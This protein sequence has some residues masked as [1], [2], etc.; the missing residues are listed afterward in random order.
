MPIRV[1][2]EIAAGFPLSVTFADVTVPSCPLVYVNPAFSKLT[3]YDQTEVLGRNCRF[4]QGENTSR[5]HIAM[6]SSAIKAALPIRIS[7]Q[8]YRKDG[9]EFTN[10]VALEPVVDGTGAPVLY[11]GL[12]RDAADGMSDEQYEALCDMLLETIERRKNEIFTARQFH[13]S[14]TQAVLQTIPSRILAVS[15]DG[16][17]GFANRAALILL[18][19]S[20]Y[21]V[22]GRPIT[23]V[24][25]RSEIG[26]WLDPE[27]PPGE[28]RFELT[29]MAPSGTRRELGISMARLDARHAGEVSHVFV[30]RDLGEWR[31]HELE[32]RR[33]KGMNALGQ[34]AA[35]FAHEVRNPLAA[36]RSLA[37]ALRSEMDATDPRAEYP[38]RMLH[39]VTRIDA[40]V[41]SALRFGAPKPPSFKICSAVR[42]VEDTIETLRPR[43]GNGP[44]PIVE[45]DYGLPDLRVDE[46]QAIEVLMNLVENALDAVG[47]PRRVRV[48]V[49]REEQSTLLGNFIRI[50]VSDDG[51]GI[52][53]EDLQRV[54]DPFFTTKTK[55]T[56]L[57]LAIAQ[58]LARENGGHLI[59]SSVPNVD[60]TFS[61]LL[62][63]AGVAEDTTTYESL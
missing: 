1:V 38:M 56:G 19:R 8:N 20:L 63:I 61:L 2:N 4:L 43:L 23:D 41:K 42:I 16:T 57:G 18:E 51:P 52:G 14:L 48:R 36:M 21:D 49:L 17:V 46:S 24:L 34:M 59:V 40:L 10:D 29:W 7:V 45:I 55:G 15:A 39:L 11:V 25:D 50:Q 33:I 37:E 53:N 22:I 60:T 13:G 31:Q 5:E 47:E 3:G 58:R 12:Q 9:S 32:L 35:G 62:P 54:F 6:F 28:H 27:L 26:K 44:R 30:F